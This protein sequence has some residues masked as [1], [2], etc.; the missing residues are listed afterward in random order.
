MKKIIF[1]FSLFFIFHNPQAKTILFL[2]DSLTEG[3][4]IDKE[5]AYPS[6]VSK[7]IKEK[8]NKEVKVINGGVSGS[9]SN[10]GLSR[11]KWYMKKKP[12]LVLI[13]LG[14][15][16]G[17]RGLN[18][19]QTKKNLEAIIQYAQKNQAK[20]L[21]AGMLMPPNYGP[22]YTGQFKKV[23]QGLKAKYKLKSMPFFLDGIAGKKELNQP[24][25][26]HPNEKGHKY[27]AKNVFEFIKDEI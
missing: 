13:A 2:G 23:Y 14:S 8:L 16:D 26:I 5:D 27:L 4:G 7:M 9:T 10:D 3:Y 12:A 11:L 22:E 20:V 17:L 19:T 25:G 6:L 1:I 15:N 24:D 18:L 21:L